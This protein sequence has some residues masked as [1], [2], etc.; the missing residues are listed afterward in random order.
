MKK[1]LSA[2]SSRFLSAAMERVKG[3]IGL[4]KYKNWT[5]AY[6]DLF[7]DL[8]MKERQVKSLAWALENEPVI[9]HDEELLFGQ[10]YMASPRSQ[11]CDFG[12][13]E[14]WRGH[15]ATSAF[16]ERVEREIP[17]LIKLT[18]GDSWIYSFFCIPGHV[19]WHWEWILEYGISGLMER[20]EQALPEADELGKENL[21]YMKVMLQ[22]VLNWNDRY[23]DA[24]RKK[25]EKCTG[26]QK[27]ELL[28]KI[29]IGK[30]VPRHGARS[31]REAVQSFHF[32][33]LSTMFENPHGGNGP[34][35]LDY[36]LHPYLERDMADGVISLPEARQ[37]IDELLV[38][39]E[40]RWC[41]I[42]EGAVETIV[43]GGC[44][45]NGM[46][47]Q[48]P[49][50]AMLIESIASL[51]I[52]HPSIY[53]RIPEQAPEQFWDLAAWDLIN[54]GNRAQVLNDSAIIKAMT[55]DG[56]IP[57]KDARMYM[58]GGCMEISPQGMNSDLL[59]T[60]FIN[61]LKILEF[62]ITGGNCL[63]TGE[64]CRPNL[65]KTLADYNR[66]EE[67]Y[68]DFIAEMR[69]LLIMHFKSMDIAADAMAKYRPRF[70]LSSQID[71]CIGRGRCIH[72]GGARYEDY[73]STPLGLPNVADS[74]TAIRIAVFEEKFISG[75]ELLA[76]L[77]CDFKDNEPLRNRLMQLPKYG[78]GD[79]EADRMAAK[80][81]SD[82]CD[83]Y[84]GYTNSRNGRIKPMIMTFMMA[85]VT[86]AVIGAS[87]DGRHKGTPI[88]QG[89]TPQS[90]S[91]SE[92]VTTAI[93]SV[94]RID[95]ERFSGGVS[96]MWDIDA[97]AAK[98]E[99]IKP[100]LKAFFDAGGQMFQ[101]NVTAVETL[102]KAQINPENYSHLLVRVGGYSGR[103]T[104]LSE[105]L[106][107]EIIHRHRHQNL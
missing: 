38:R 26:R 5:H 46:P 28:E 97:S 102:K 73:G 68:Q 58:C 63:M 67:L 48:T 27:A 64:K 90:S 42:Y 80:I 19:G 81:I 9:L 107:D 33:Y 6:F 49:L 71:D 54:G 78:Q 104:T 16:M 45:G 77:R 66:F 52:A 13:N 47:H 22:A 39:F 57:E 87:P 40:E 59:F 35:R 99:V 30:R 85:P 61:I 72:E 44:D 83:I 50:T 15:D 84:D 31:F 18:G 32:T 96:N 91:M 34:G 8:P 56:H 70:L 76:A 92:G 75:T 2:R 4:E 86:G 88:S 1:E 17:D 100:L 65:H 51:N 60:G 89:I 82:T 36:Y 41:F 105:I 101:G 55:R 106:Q 103:F 69:N 24:M 37:L 98:P 14:N 21:L 94:G 20:I 10:V 23:V 74:L 53:L 62:V 12:G 95:L 79:L 29:A 25:A 43:I 93:N 7:V 11:A 3:P